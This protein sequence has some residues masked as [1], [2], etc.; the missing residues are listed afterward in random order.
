MLSVVFFSKS[1][2]ISSYYKK[3][4]RFFIHHPPTGLTI[5]CRTLKFWLQR[6]FDKKFVLSEA[7]FEIQSTAW[8]IY[9]FMPKIGIFWKISFLGVSPPC[10][11][12]GDIQLTI[13][14]LDRN[15]KIGKISR[16]NIK[17]P[18]SSLKCLYLIFPKFSAHHIHHE[19]NDRIQQ[20]SGDGRHMHW[21]VL[22]L[23]MYA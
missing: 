13:P 2:Q 6:Y 5:H 15:W 1:L 7:I 3:L 19:H 9:S 18:C 4:S 20:T 23:L 11:Y 21:S 10:G 16:S 14:I 17:P 8:D 22:R 12:G